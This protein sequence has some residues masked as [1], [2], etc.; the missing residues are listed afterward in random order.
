LQFQLAV[1]I[2]AI[3]IIFFGSVVTEQATS[4]MSAVQLLWINLIMVS[5]YFDSS[6]SISIFFQCY[7]YFSIILYIL[8]FGQT[9]CQGL[10]WRSWF[11]Q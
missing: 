10:S 7:L 6:S 2:S 4:P 8:I 3:C 9:Q 11:G 1:N 5:L